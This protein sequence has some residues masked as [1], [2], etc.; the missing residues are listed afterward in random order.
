MFWGVVIK[1]ECTNIQT[2]SLDWIR[3]EGGSLLEL[4]SPQPT[5]YVSRHTP[6]CNHSTK[7]EDQTQALAFPRY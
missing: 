3:E 4:I 7:P 5:S 1:V 6:K 2:F